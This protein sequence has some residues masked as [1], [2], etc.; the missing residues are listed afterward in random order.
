M[1]SV[2]QLPG[3]YQ[4]IVNCKKLYL[5][6]LER[7]P[8]YGYAHYKYGQYLYDQ[9][10][11]IR[12]CDEDSISEMCR[13]Y[14]SGLKL[15]GTTFGLRSKENTAFANCI[16][17]SLNFSQVKKLNPSSPRQW[18][19][20]GYEMGK[21]GPGYLDRNMPFALKHLADT[22][23]GR[24][25]YCRMAKGLEKAGLPRS[26]AQVIERFLSA[27]ITD[28]RAW[29]KLVH[30][31]NRN[32]KTF[33]KEEIVLILN[34]AMDS[35]TP[36]ESTSIDF[37]K[38]ACE[39]GAFQLSKNFFAQALTLAP[40]NP[41]IFASYGDCSMRL[42]EYDTAIQLYKKSIKLDPKSG[43]YLVS[44]AKAY[45]RLNKFQLAEKQLELA[46]RLDPNNKS[47]KRA[48]RQMGIY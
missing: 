38:T 7:Y 18:E 24:H 21:K 16:S 45:T 25:D 41:G 39:Y 28:A 34:R 20:I 3:I 26:G 8:V 46:L 27:N 6:V 48:L 1:C 11:M 43:R 14:G 9:C 17:M 19:L 29:S 36:E 47:A 32:R 22:R 10:L 35:A 44:L 40:T 12:S 5:A 42:G 13:S 31:M 23:S 2:K 30:M 4:D 37:G 15:M 33:S